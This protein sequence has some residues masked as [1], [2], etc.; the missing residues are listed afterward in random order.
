MKNTINKKK[1][2]AASL[3][4]LL[5]CALNLSCT[6]LQAQYSQG[7]KPF[8]FD[9]TF[10]EF[11]IQDLKEN[12]LPS[13]DLASMQSEDSVN[14]QSKGPFRFGYNHDV[15]FSL[16]NSGTWLTLPNGDRLWQFLIRSPGALSINLAFDDF[17]MPEGANLFVYNADKDFV[18]GAFTSINNQ[19]DK[20]FATD[21]ITGDAV[22]LEYY[23]PA[24]VS[25]QGHLKLFR[26][27]HGYRGVKD[28]L[29]KAF[30]NAGSCQK[31]INCP[32]GANWQN[33]KNSVVLI[34]TTGN[35]ICSGAL[36]N[37]VPQDSKPYVLTANHCDHPGYGTWVFRFKWESPTCTNPGSSP[38]SLSLTGS[39]KRAAYPG[40]DMLLMEITGGLA[41]QTIPAIYQPYFSGW[42][43]I[44]T[45]ATSAVCIH[46]PNGDIKKISEAL[47][48]TQSTNFT[49]APEIN[50]SDSWRIGQWT[51]GCT[52]PG[53]SGSP[54]YDQNKRIVGQLGGG[55][56]ACGASAINLYDCYGK[57]STSWLGGGS[58]STQ[59]K[60]WLDPNNTGT[61]TM[62]G[63]DTLVLSVTTRNEETTTSFTTYP[64]PSNGELKI[65]LKMVKLQ[66]VTAKVLNLL[67]QV[68]YAKSFSD[69]STGTYQLDVSSEPDGI[70]FL[71]IS[72]ATESSVKK[73][74]IF[75]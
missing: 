49:S 25:N 58:D 7:G 70:Y 19:K 18:I 52:E 30:G 64:N 71:E 9:N 69:A 34:I 12:I 68:I 31:N 41:F 11:S 54:L 17:F 24:A 65:D 57:F 50:N 5:F 10:R 55:P 6:L 60:H 44:N 75:R 59:L 28:Y 36:V 3:F 46:H 27:T 43:N 29:S 45:P 61:Q 21:L 33:Q 26:V 63:T 42:S 32:I 53:S 47:N 67:G 23:E 15:N 16:N 1:T 56:S 39:V 2:K 38:S 4:F 74:N 22:V 37:D 48:A 66:N 72:T 14:D 73:I 51:T 62:N 40:S 20:Q 8:S 13:F 35:V